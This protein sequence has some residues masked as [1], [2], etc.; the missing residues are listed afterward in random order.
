MSDYEYLMTSLDEDIFIPTVPS[1]LGAMLMSKVSRQ[2]EGFR[3]DLIK[4]VEKDM[5]N[6]PKVKMY[7]TFKSSYVVAN[8]F[9]EKWGVNYGHSSI[10]ELDTLQ[11]CIERRSRWFTEILETVQASKFMSYIEYSLRYNPPRTYYSPTEFEAHPELLQAYKAFCDYCFDTYYGLKDDFVELFEK[12]YPKMSAKDIEIKAFENAR[13]VLPLSTH[14]NMGLQSNLRAFCDAISELAAYE[15]IND[16]IYSSAMKMKQEAEK[17]SV[18]MVRHAEKTPYLES[19]VRAFYAEEAGERNRRERTELGLKTGELLGDV[20]RIEHYG[21]LSLMSRFDELPNVFKTV[22]RNVT[23]YLS[24][25]CHHQ[26]LRHRA[27]DFRAH[28][29]NV[30]YGYINPIESKLGDQ[31]EIEAEIREKIAL[32]FEKSCEI[33]DKIKV[34]GYKYLAPYVVIN[35]N[36]RKVSFFGNFYALS[37]F[38]TLRREPHSQDEIRHF[39]DALY[40]AFKKDETLFSGLHFDKNIKQRSESGKQ[41]G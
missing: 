15:G 35:A 6:L 28:M 16:E 27:F 25:G 9:M 41:D 33:Y 38:I 26:F 37:H 5:V 23:A 2:K 36:A 12:R 22:G 8:G 19:F 4:M 11:M 21:D 1:V 39:A 31:P 29:P 40:E 14:A 10:K 20:S 30:D 18:G 13:N 32:C 34:A 24:E 17:V 7:D 3:E